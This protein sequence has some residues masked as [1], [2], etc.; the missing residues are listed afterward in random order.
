MSS[1]RNRYPEEGQETPRGPRGE[2]SQVDRPARPDDAAKLKTLSIQR[3]ELEFVQTRLNSC[4]Q[5]VSN[6]LTT[7]S[8][9]EILAMEKPVVQQVKD[10]C[11]EFDTSKL[12]PYRSVQIWHSQPIANSSQYAS[13][14]FGQV[15]SGVGKGLE[16][17]TVGEQNTVT[18]YA[19][20][21]EGI[22][23]VLNS[24]HSFS[25]NWYRAVVRIKCEVKPSKSS[26]YQIDYLPTRRGRHQLDIKICDQHGR[27]N[28][29][30]VVVLRKC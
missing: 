22:V 11:V 26:E 18:V 24:S 19:I 4:L 8:E 14:Q 5:F 30:T 9:E 15:C 29:F 2:E 20:D 13:M 6:S 3:D 7:G 17:A 25:V 23:S 28:P 12:T 21:I 27:G 10:M 16:V 1:D